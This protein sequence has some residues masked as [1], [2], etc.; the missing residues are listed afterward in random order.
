MTNQPKTILIEA[1]QAGLRLDAFLARALPD[2]SRKKAAALIRDG[3][4][5]LDGKPA[6]KAA[7]LRAGQAVTI[8]G[9]SEQRP[10]AAEPE[11]SL[12]ILY[13]DEWFVAAAKPAG[14]HT[15]PLAAGDAGTLAQAL[16]GRYPEM[17]GIGARPN[18]PGVCHRLDF[19]TSGVVLAART[20]EAFAAVRA[21]FAAH[22][23]RKIY[24]ALCT[25]APPP[26]FRVAAPIGHPSRR[27]GRVV[28]GAGRGRIPAVTDCQT[29]EKYT[30]ASLV[31]ATTATG[32]MH[33]IRAHL[34]FAGYP[35]IGDILY[36]G[37]AAPGNRFWLH[38]L[39]IRFPH[40]HRRRLMTVECPRPEWVW[41]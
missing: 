38:A 19:W 16:L 15:V 10:I 14:L 27:T 30:G 28:V 17:T 25:D 26:T 5:R 23:I 22:R 18:E 2:L 4:V 21:A 3:A 11:A 31:R 7:I 12:T 34:A 35:L 37:P 36:G 6:A 9:V 1:E 8:T 32:A 39:S 13:E 24:L 33:Q 40:P 41:W 20:R 29:I